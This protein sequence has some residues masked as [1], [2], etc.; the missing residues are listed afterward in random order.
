[1]IVPNFENLKSYAVHKGLGE[2]D[3]D[4]LVQLPEVIDLIQRRIARQQ[5]GAAPFETIKRVH[6]LNREMVIGEELT[7]T[8]K[9]KRKEVGKRFHDEIEALYSG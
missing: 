9:V 2:T 7:P 4:K 8:M 6:I 5:Q 3:P 1:L